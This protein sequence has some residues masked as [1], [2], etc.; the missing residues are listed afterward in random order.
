MRNIIY[1]A[2]LLLLLDCAADS[3]AI[4]ATAEWPSPKHD[5]SYIPFDVSTDDPAFTIC[6]STRI[7]S[8]RNRLRYHEG[9]NAFKE[10]V[11]AGFTTE[12]AFADFNGYV[13]VR[14]LVNCEGISGRYRAEALQLDFSPAKVDPALL[15]QALELIKSLNNWTKATDSAPETE[16]F[17]FVNLKI[18]NGD[19]QH[20]LL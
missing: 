16:Y 17:K 8:G 13:V 5:L 14:F 11:M 10:A 19:I 6:D 2:L 12:P 18:E 20:I 15:A 9:T 1:V 4:S 7:R 3:S